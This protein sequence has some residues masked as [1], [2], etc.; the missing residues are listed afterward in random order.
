MRGRKRNRTWRRLTR[1]SMRRRAASTPAFVA[2][3]AQEAFAVAP[4]DVRIADP[5]VE[6][7]PMK[8]DRCG[9][10]NASLKRPNYCG[11]CWRAM[12]G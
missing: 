1:Q 5:E 12:R 3:P 10:P 7:E 8:C 2:P 11:E 6:R 4:V 9:R